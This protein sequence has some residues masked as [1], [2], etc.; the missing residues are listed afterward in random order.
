MKVYHAQVKGGRIEIHNLA[1]FKDWCRENEGSFVKIITGGKRKVSDALRGWYYGAIIPRLKQL[2]REWENE[3]EETIH[4]LLKQ[5]FDG[6]DIYS[7][8]QKEKVRV[9][10]SVMSSSA[11]TD[12]ALA[13]TERI[14]RWMEENYGESLPDPSEYIKRRDEVN[15]VENKIDYPKD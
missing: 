14:G 6:V 3:H 15:K 11:T 5:E 2:V 8:F 4:N 1:H 13:F 7:P 12:S 9:S 10:G